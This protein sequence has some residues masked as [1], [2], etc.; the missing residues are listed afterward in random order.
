MFST[1]FRVLKYGTESVLRNIWLSLITVSTA[2]LA[3]L[4]VTMLIALQV[5]IS[6]IVTAAEE[7]IDLGVYFY[8]TVTDAQVSSVVTVLNSFP[9]VAEVTY[10]SREQAL[11]NYQQRAINRPELMKSLEAIGQNPFGTSLRVKAHSQADYATIVNELSKP[12]Y[13]DLIEGQQADYQEN[14]AFITSFTSFTERAR[15]TGLVVSAVLGAIA[16]LLIFNAVRV[17]IY[18]H[19]DEI[20]IMK[21]VGASNWFVRAPFL[22]ETFLYG[23]MAV[24]VTIGA[25]YGLLSFIQPGLER[26]FGGDVQLLG[27]FKEH[28]LA[29]FG[30]EL[31]VIL[32]MNS[33]SG[34]IALRR[35]L[36]V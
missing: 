35:Y 34:I 36:R 30:I 11:A 19:R 15:T 17:A 4:A 21:L 27:Y 29:I 10:V 16:V 25:T 5:G 31:G 9:G 18:T 22:V 12:Q 1:F 2:A 14:T 3:L 20:A 26:Y 13:K 8:P 32:L 28:W 33:L 24:I 23:L 6:Q 7:R